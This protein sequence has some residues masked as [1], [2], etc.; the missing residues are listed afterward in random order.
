MTMFVESVV[1][2]VDIIDKSK[3]RYKMSK[4]M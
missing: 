4:Y 3:I 2:V 1:D